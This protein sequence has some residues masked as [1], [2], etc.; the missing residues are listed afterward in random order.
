MNVNMCQRMRH[1]FNIFY[2]YFTFCRTLCNRTFMSSVNVY[3]PVQYILKVA[4]LN[5]EKKNPSSY[6]STCVNVELIET[7]EHDTQSQ[8]L[9]TRILFKHHQASE[10]KRSMR[11]IN[12]LNWTCSEE[13]KLNWGR[14]MNHVNECSIFVLRV[15]EILQQETEAFCNDASH[16]FC[17]LEEERCIQEMQ[18]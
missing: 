17:L 4:T 13:C 8:T 11:I 18:I 14:Q 6:S 10:C 3:V 9:Y 5:D 12:T 2:T 15:C 7:F 1:I 16:L